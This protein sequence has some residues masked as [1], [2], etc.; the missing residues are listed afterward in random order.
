MLPHESGR[1][2][3][4]ARCS[5]AMFYASVIKLSAHNFLLCDSVACMTWTM[6]I[7]A[8]RTRQQVLVECQVLQIT[9]RPPCKRQCA[10]AFREHHHFAYTAQSS[11]QLQN[12][13]ARQADS[14]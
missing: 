14:R 8:S 10:C 2:P 11:M 7:A 3:A 5:I 1:G 9:Q 12:L 4:D 13:K 6:A